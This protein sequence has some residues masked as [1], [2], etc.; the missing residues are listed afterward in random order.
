MIH[1]GFLVTKKM[2]A[3][4]PREDHTLREYLLG[5]EV[6]KDGR[7]DHYN[8]SGHDV[9][10]ID[11]VQGIEGLQPDRQCPMVRALQIDQWLIEIIPGVEKMKDRDRD[12]GRTSLRQDN[13]QQGLQRGCSIDLGGIVQLQRNGHEELPE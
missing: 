8:R 6:E 2:L 9:M 11:G 7:Q 13:I 5:E 3:L 4:D 10:R 12:Q 1:D